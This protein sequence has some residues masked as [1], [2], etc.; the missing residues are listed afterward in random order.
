M[1]WPRGQTLGHERATGQMAARVSPRVCDGHRSLGCRGNRAAFDIARGRR[2]PDRPGPAGAYPA[3][4]AYAN[5]DDADRD[6]AYVH[7]AYSG[8]SNRDH[9]Y[10]DHTYRGDPA[11]E[12]G[13]LH[14]LG[15]GHNGAATA[16]A[17]GNRASHVAK[18]GCP[19]TGLAARPDCALC[20]NRGITAP[21]VRRA[22][23]CNPS[24]SP[25]PCT[26]TNRRGG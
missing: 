8:H 25:D 15:S 11:V 12:R 4:P 19:A 14:G 5:R 1:H 17:I 13:R 7:N 9:T 21:P 10:R 16:A 3:V 26:G 24:D 23:R 6:H 22:E 20:G 2:H 18:R